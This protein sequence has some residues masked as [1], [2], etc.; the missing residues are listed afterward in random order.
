MEP[1][2]ESDREDAS[3]S[4]LTK[5]CISNFEKCCSRKDC[6]D[7]SSLE[8]GLADLR[9]W[10]YGVGATADGS[11]SLDSRFKKRPEDIMLVKTILI[12]LNGFLE[13]YYTS[14]DY[15]AVEENTKSIRSSL[16]NLATIGLAIRR[17]GTASRQRRAESTF[18]PKDYEELQKHLECIILLRP[19]KAGLPMHLDSSDLTIVQRRLIE[20]NLMRR[21]RT[22][23]AHRRTRYG[24][25]DRTPQSSQQVAS[26]AEWIAQHAGEVGSQASNLQRNTGEQLKQKLQET[27]T[28]G[29]LSAASTAEGTLRYG[30]SRDYKPGVAKTNITAIGNDMEFP[31]APLNTEGRLIGR[32]PCCFQSLG[33]ELINDPQKWRQHII[34]DMCPYTCIIEDCPKPKL[35]FN[36]RRE[37]EAHVQTDHGSQWT[38]P[39]CEDVE[40]SFLSEKDIV[41]HFEDEHHDAIEQFEVSNLLD[42]SKSPRMGISTCP[43]CSSFGREDSPEII[44]HVLKHVYE[45][46]LRALPWPTPSAAFDFGAQIGTYQ[47]PGDHAKANRL[48]GWIQDALSE[49]F[50]DPFAD[51]PVPTEDMKYPCDHIQRSRFDRADQRDEELVQAMDETHYVPLDEYFDIHQIN[52][53]AEPEGTTIVSMLEYHSANENNENNPSDDSAD[54]TNENN[55]PV[56][57]QRVN[58]ILRAEHTVNIRCALTAAVHGTMSAESQYE[59]T[60][61][62]FQ[63]RFLPE[64]KDR[65][66]CEANIELRFDA[67]GPGNRFPEVECISFEGIHRVLPTIQTKTTTTGLGG[68]I[69][70]SYG[71]AIDTS[72]NIERTVSRD[73]SSSTIIEGRILSVNNKP[74]SRVAKWT[75]RED[76][77]LKTGV[78]TFIQVAVRI[79]RLDDAVFT[80]IPTLK[81]KMNKRSPL[82][83]MFGSTLEEDP[84][85]LDPKTRPTDLAEVYNADELGSID[86][87]AL[88]DVML[89]NESESPEVRFGVERQ[90]SLVKP[91]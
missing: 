75:I 28:V 68:G 46:S 31:K 63:F 14:T 90:K 80:C 64:R 71:A 56:E 41:Q 52:D 70:V 10:D 25:R 29:V 30:S 35:L 22:V 20:A 11:S 16:K 59:A 69:G 12:I 84:I 33:M 19:S 60:L 23:I 91:S 4:S 3:I 49:P 6:G 83:S 65:R 27:R 76:K 85:L 18:N 40:T 1:L 2:L 21:H 55:P 42:W 5:A 45:F 34:E 77:T 53:S 13:E 26:D 57:F 24:Q 47:V 87:Q 81:C 44:D 89:Y 32:C 61:L 38:C 74:P 58:F 72:I 8:N 7:T 51:P 62:I 88:G 36:T 67:A 39:L 82:A 37:W 79:M 73:T 17:T 86:L 9:L 15:H 48:T 54:V 43:L 50:E 78:P 66:V